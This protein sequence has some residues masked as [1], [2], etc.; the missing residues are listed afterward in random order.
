MEGNLGIGTRKYTSAESK[1]AVFDFET[2]RKGRERNKE[3]NKKV[4]FA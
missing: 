4:M 2:K 1:S 3:K